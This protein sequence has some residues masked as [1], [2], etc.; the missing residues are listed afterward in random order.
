MPRVYLIMASLLR[1]SEWQ[2]TSSSTMMLV[3]TAHT[4]HITASAGNARTYARFSSFCPYNLQEFTAF[5]RRSVVESLLDRQD[6]VAH[7]FD[8]IFPVAS[9]VKGIGSAVR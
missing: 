6:V 4:N 3:P 8:M 2:S 9:S 1:H 5:D 7:L